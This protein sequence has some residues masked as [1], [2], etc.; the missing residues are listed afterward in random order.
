LLQIPQPLDGIG[1]NRAGTNAVDRLRGKRH[2]PPFGER[3]NGP[4]NDV[5]SI[6]G[7][8]YIDHNWRHG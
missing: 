2:Q 4:M 6:L 5:S 8:S 3:L 1:M 7:V